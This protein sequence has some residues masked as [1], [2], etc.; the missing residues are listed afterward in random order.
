MDL[1]LDYQ[2]PDEESDIQCQ[3]IKNLTT[4]EPITET[5]EIEECNITT[6]SVQ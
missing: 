2:E 3:E 4:P 1:K 5:E 6:I